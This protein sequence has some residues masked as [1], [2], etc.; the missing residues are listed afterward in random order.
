MGQA[1]SVCTL[2]LTGITLLTI[3]DKTIGD[4]IDMNVQMY[5]QLVRICLIR[6]GAIGWV[7]IKSVS[8]RQTITLQNQ[9]EKVALVRNH[10]TSLLPLYQN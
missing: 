4:E 5:F 3:R 2:A 6:Q 10:Y 7:W 8:S 1:R 9:P